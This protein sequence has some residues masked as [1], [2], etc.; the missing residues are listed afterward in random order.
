MIFFTPYLKE[1]DFR[2]LEMLLLSGLLPG[3]PR[4]RNPG[5]RHVGGRPLLQSGHP[6]H[7]ALLQQ[8]K[9]KTM[10]DMRMMELL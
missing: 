6:R 10:K 1:V 5:R 3:L 7:P 2:Y 4:R 9:G 8:N